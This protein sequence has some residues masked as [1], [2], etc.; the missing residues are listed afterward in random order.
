MKT[1]KAKALR[2]IRHYFLILE[3][4]VELAMGGDG[5]FTALTAPWMA[6]PSLLQCER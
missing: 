6:V 3:D 5:A 4:D 1:L 2:L